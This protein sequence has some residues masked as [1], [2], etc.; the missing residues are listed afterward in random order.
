M[1]NQFIGWLIIAVTL[2]FPF[3]QMYFELEDISNFH[4]ALY[5]VIAIAGL[6]LGYYIIGNAKEAAKKEH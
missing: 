3:N 1:K 5:F 2:A 6:G 4:K